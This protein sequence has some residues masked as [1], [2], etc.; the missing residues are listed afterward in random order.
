MLIMHAIN[1]TLQISLVAQEPVLYDCSIRNNISYGCDWATDEDVKAAAQLADV[2][3][4]IMQLEKRYE[5][6]CGERGIQLSGG[7]K[8]RIAI[9]RAL[10]RKP[11]VVIFDEATSALDAHAENAIQEALKR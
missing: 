5:T 2:H 6:Y 8:Q 9:A 7:Q 10:V 3:D 4:W 1:V 11:A